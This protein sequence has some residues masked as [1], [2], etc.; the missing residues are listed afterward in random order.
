[1]QVLLVHVSEIREAYLGVCRPGPGLD[2][3]ESSFWLYIDEYPE[4]GG[5]P[6]HRKDGVESGKVFGR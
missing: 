4:L 1:M 6:V 2:A 3:S 5:I